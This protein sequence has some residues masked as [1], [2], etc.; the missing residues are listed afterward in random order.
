MDRLGWS[1]GQPHRGFRT[2]LCVRGVC[3]KTRQS[4]NLVYTCCRLCTLAKGQ[5]E[6][7]ISTVK[8]IMRQTELHLGLKGPV[9]MK[10]AGIEAVSALNQRPGA[11]GVS[12]AMMLFGQKLKLYGELYEDGEPAYHHLDVND[13]S[14]E[15]GR[16]FQYDVQPDRLLKLIMPRKWFAKLCLLEQ[17]MSK[18]LMLVN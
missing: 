10:Y 18:K 3:I 9:D 6:R 17:D 1:S 11:S 14:T 13:A 7:K 8:S 4:W 5:V 15:L 16:R 12:A 2:W